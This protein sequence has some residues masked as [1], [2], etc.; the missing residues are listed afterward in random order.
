MVVLIS[1]EGLL[2][3]SRNVLWEC[4]WHFPK[5]LSIK[6]EILPCLLSYIRTVFFNNFKKKRRKYF[7]GF[8]IN[9]LLSMYL[10]TCYLKNMNRLKIAIFLCWNITFLKFVF[11]IF[12]KSKV[13][14]HPC[15]GSSLWYTNQNK[16]DIIS[17][18]L[19]EFWI[20]LITFN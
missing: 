13:S 15:M 19:K 7:N 8:F 17:D 11:Q 1:L 6:Y 5:S 4:W 16:M 10:S 12:N 18:L 2:E 9:E 3:M 20:M 14:S